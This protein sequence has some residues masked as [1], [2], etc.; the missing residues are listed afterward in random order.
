[1]DYY[2]ISE[3][4]VVHKRQYKKMHFKLIIPI[5][6]TFNTCDIVYIFFLHWNISSEHLCVTGHLHLLSKLFKF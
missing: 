1:M 6:L 2:P 5:I 3:V 4:E